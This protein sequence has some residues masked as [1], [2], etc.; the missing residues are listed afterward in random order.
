MRG[1]TALD[2]LVQ[3]G[4]AERNALG[5]VRVVK[6]PK[7]QRE[8]DWF[9]SRLVKLGQWS[10]GDARCVEISSGYNPDSMV[11]RGL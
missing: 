6:A 8:L 9:V 10:T 3:A 7:N 4:Y 1:N 5:I 11:F 2:E